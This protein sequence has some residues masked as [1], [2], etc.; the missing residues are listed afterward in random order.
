MGRRCPYLH[1]R[2]EI[3][4][5]FWKDEHGRRHEESLRTADL[6]HAKDRYRERVDEIANGRSPNDR[7]RWT[8]RHACEDWLDRRR[9]VIARGSYQAEKSIVQRLQRVFGPE[10]VLRSIADINQIHEYQHKRLTEGVSAKT[11]N[12]ETLVLMGILRLAQLWQRVYGYKPFR[13]KRSDLPD[14]LTVDESKNLVQGAADA[15][16]MAVAPFAAAL[17]FGTGLRSGEIKKIRLGDLHD[18]ETFPFLVVRRATTKTDAG[19]R[20]VALGKIAVWALQKLKRRALLIG[21]RKPSDYLLPTDCSRHTRI[22]DPLHGTVGFDPRHSQSSWE[23]EWV[24]FREA[25]GIRHR[26][27]HDLRHTYITRAAEAGV[28]MA[29]LETQVGHMNSQMVRWYT[30]VSSRAQHEAA[31]RIEADNPE[32][33]TVLGLPTEKVA[34]M[35]RLSPEDNFVNGPLGE[36]VGT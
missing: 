23:W 29:V 16:P 31:R 24:E 13:T 30:H 22:S 35:M 34:V 36:F 32:L 25:A 15:Q 1:R 7:S 17:A 27:F 14:A 2:G 19:A 5:F 28:P 10:R 33:L 6:Q 8:L 18:D 4:Y 9:F 20:R 3:F 11:V 21:S 26:R 12:N